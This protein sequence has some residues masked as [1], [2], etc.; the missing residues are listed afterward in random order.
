MVYYCYT[1]IIVSSIQSQ[2]ILVKITGRTSP[3]MP[4]PKDFVVP[5]PPVFWA[6]I[7]TDRNHR[8]KTSSPSCSFWAIP[9]MILSD[10]LFTFVTGSYSTGSMK[11]HP[12]SYWVHQ[13]RVQPALAAA[14]RL[15]RSSQILSLFWPPARASSS[16]YIK[17]IHIPWWRWTCSPFIGLY[18][19][20]DTNLQRS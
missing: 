15:R 7:T 4:L 18:N 13:C 11:C 2:P 20:C 19:H 8:P 16:T 17:Y 3:A 12:C 6:N 14:R 9:I 5:V 10:Y 1:N